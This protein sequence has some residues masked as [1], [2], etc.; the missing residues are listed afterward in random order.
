MKIALVDDHKLLLTALKK[1]LE[2]NGAHQVTVFSSAMEFL[3]SLK[4]DLPDLLVTDLQMP[5]VS[6]L[7]LVH[8]VKDQY[9]NIKILVLSMIVEPMVIKKMKK[10]G[11]QGYVQKKHDLPVLMNAIET[12]LSGNDFYDE[13]SASIVSSD[14][15]EALLDLTKREKEVLKL[16]ALEMSS[17]EIADQ[18]SLSVHTVKTFR[19]SLLQKFGTNKTLGM[20]LKAMELNLI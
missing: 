12:I 20:V 10:S 1:S 16:L 13:D 14:K 17:E 11:V 15:V 19:K 2:G 18:L 8:E 7:E 3:S 5:K 6:G 4:I 9:P